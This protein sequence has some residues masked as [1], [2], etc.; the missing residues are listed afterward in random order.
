[1]LKVSS[2]NFTAVSKAVHIA[3]FKYF[4]KLLTMPYKGKTQY[5]RLDSKLCRH[6]FLKHFMTIVFECVL[7]IQIYVHEHWVD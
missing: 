1:M 7:P 5:C 3:I 2:A 4:K 6:N